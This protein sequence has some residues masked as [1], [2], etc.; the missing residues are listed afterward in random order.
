MPARLLSKRV[1]IGLSGTVLIVAT[2]AFLLPKIAD[3]RDV[4]QVVQG[5]VVGVGP[6]AR[7]ESTVYRPRDLAPPW[8]VAS[9]GPA[10]L[11]GDDDDPGDDR[12]LA[13]GAGWSRRQDRDLLRDVAAAGFARRT[14]ARR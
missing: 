10:V 2:F 8:L 13:G 7:R 14:I 4:W 11:A 9:A 3:Y 5:R 6:G 1:L 12:A